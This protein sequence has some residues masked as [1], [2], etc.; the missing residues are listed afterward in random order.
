VTS[1]LPEEGKTTVAS[2]LAYTLAVSGRRTL[3]VECDL[4]RPRLS[5]RLGISRSPGLTDFLAGA[6]RPQEVVRAIDLGLGR[7]GGSRTTPPA[8]SA[9]G[10][11]ATGLLACITAGSRTAHAAEL[12][13]SPAFAQFLDEVAE[14]YDIVVLDTAPLLPVADTLE[15]LPNVDAVLVCL[16]ASRTTRDQA[17][18]A[19]AALGRVSERPAGVVVTGARDPGDYSTYYA[20]AY[21]E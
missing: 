21:D 1:A 15:L 5:E 8:S 13:G 19:R 12:L 3:L 10:I 7:N 17:M 18:A 20:Y 16:R 2:S 9:L 4:R 14:A 6:A 11:P